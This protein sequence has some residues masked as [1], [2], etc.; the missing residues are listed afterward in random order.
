MGLNTK[1]LGAQ[2]Q[3]LTAELKAL[4]QVRSCRYNCEML[5]TILEMYATDHQ[6]L[7]P[8]SLSQVLSPSWPKQPECPAAGR[9]TYSSSYQVSPDLNAYTISCKGRN[10]EAAGLGQ[11]SPSFNSEGLFDEAS[12]ALSAPA[13]TEP[14]DPEW[15]PTT[16]EEVE[17]TVLACVCYGN[18]RIIAEQLKAY[19]AG[20][21]GLFP[22]GLGE[23]VPGYL[24]S[25]PTCPAAEK[26]TY[27]LSYLASAKGDDYAFYC[28]GT[29]H[30][31]PFLGTDRPRMA[32]GTPR[33]DDGLEECLE[34]AKG[35]N[36]DMW[37]NMGLIVR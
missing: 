29:N 2:E 26:D 23:L 8:R 13:A 3:P 32:P 27:S 24:K 4:I 22:R 37:R 20:H 6:G 12:S 7:Y 19:A 35:L 14:S 9:D 34:L 30:P 31:L 25:I 16:D 11:D 10:H 5:G 28:Q 33:E 36:V 21:Q 17:Q 15:Q 1:E 18:T